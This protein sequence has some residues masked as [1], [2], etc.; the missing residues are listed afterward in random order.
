MHHPQQPAII[1]PNH[2][3]FGPALPEESLDPL[4]A[5][6]HDHALA[7]WEDEGGAIHPK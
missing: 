7:A 1:G 3:E 4:A 5:D 6:H 2:N